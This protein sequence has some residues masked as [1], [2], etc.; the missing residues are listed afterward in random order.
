MHTTFSRALS[1]IESI[2]NSFQDRPTIVYRGMSRQHIERIL[3]RDDQ[4]IE[5]GKLLSRLFFYGEKAKAFY[6]YT[7]E[8]AQLLPWLKNIEDSSEATCQEIFKRINALLG[9]TDECLDFHLESPQFCDFFQKKENSSKFTSEVSELGPRA[10]DYYLY[11]L[12]S[13]NSKY[14]NESFLVSTTSSFEYA[15]EFASRGDHK[16][17][18]AYLIP[19]PSEMHAINAESHS[20]SERILESRGLPVYNGAAHHP[21]E[22]EH[23][24]R[25]ALFAN[26][27][28]G[29]FAIEAGY[30]YVNPHI[31]NEA[32]C[33][34]SI[35]NG[36]I[37]EQEDF[38]ERIGET[39]YQ[40]GVATFFE[41]S[42]RSVHI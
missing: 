14:L 17:V 7:E 39:Q 22:R 3:S 15:K 19:S 28:V 34:S 13:Y 20:S 23:A 41:G 25:G 36:L 2:E 33:S 21:D 38:E 35:L 42:L 37:V 18:I 32:N 12:H 8:E 40:R 29:V 9:Q 26:H 30:F 10:R 1:E 24:I 27:M 4:P 16:L 6:H 31:F 5:E 11:F